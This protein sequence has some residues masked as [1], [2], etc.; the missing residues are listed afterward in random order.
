MP[1]GDSSL[2]RH[3]LETEALLLARDAQPLAHCRHLGF[4]QLFVHRLALLPAPDLSVLGGG[5]PLVT[6]LPRIVGDPS[7]RAPAA[8]PWADVRAAARP[9]R[10]PPLHPASG[11]SL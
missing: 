6:N 9:G 3:I 7:R 5:A 11:P 2:G 10:A 8:C 1:L 4:D